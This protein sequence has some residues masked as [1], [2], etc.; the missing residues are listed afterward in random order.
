MD[1]KRKIPSLD[2][3][4]SANARLQAEKPISSSKSSQSLLDID[5]MIQQRTGNVPSSSQS[6]SQNL[7][8]KSDERMKEYQKNMEKFSNFID[9]KLKE[10]ISDHFDAYES[11]KT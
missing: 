1:I 3:P 4:L 6:S 5:L 7:P 8:R 10:K 9:S 2:I 11:F